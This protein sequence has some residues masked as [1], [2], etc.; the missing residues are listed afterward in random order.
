MCS[1]APRI[2]WAR[3]LL[4][5]IP[6][7]LVLTCCSLAAGVLLS[8]VCRNFDWLSR[9]GALLICWGILLLARPSFSGIEIGQHVYAEDD[10]MSLDDPEYYKKK[11]EPVPWWAADRAKSRLATGVLGPLVCFI[12]TL[13]NGFASLLNGPLGFVP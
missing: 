7:M 2:G 6:F 5:S 9:F 4:A 10:D 3:K 13:A 11:G 8:V 12:G 1:E